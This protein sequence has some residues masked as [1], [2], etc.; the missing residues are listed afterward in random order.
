MGSPARVEERQLRKFRRRSLA[1]ATVVCLTVT[2][3]LVRAGNA[4]SAIRLGDGIGPIRLGMTEAQV[5]RAL[6]RPDNVRR[7]RAGRIHIVS[8]NYYLRGE[9]RVTLRGPR[10]GVRVSLVGT[11]SRQQRTPG[12]LGIGSSETRLRDTYPNLRCKDVRGTGGG[13]I[14]RE[15]RVG[16][17]RRRHSVFVIGRGP[18]PPVVIEILVVAGT[19]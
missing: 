16:S 19:G 7:A 5:R 14:R 2:A 9:Y 15:C 8:L 6:G 13:V 18:N 11:I 3:G 4:D 1:S 17:A 10:G 12:G